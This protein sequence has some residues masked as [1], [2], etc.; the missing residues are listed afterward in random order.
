MDIKRRLSRQVAVGDIK[1]GGDAPISVQS[2]LNTKTTDVEGSIRQI[3][4]LKE[5]GCDLIRLAVPD[6]A[7]CEAF[8]KIARR[9]GLPL[10][11]D[12]H[13]SYKLAHLAL[14]NGAKKIR[15]NPGNMRD[16]AE[17]KP[18]AKHMIDMGVPVRVGV[19]GGSLDPK[20]KGM[21]EAKALS[22]S[23]LECAN[24]FESQG[25]RDIVVAIKASDT[26]IN[27]E[28]N[29]ILA[30]ACDYPLHIG[31]TE[32][33]TLRTGLIKSAIGIGTLLSE[34]IGDTIRV[35]LSADVTEEVL[36]GKKILQTLGVKKNAV[37]VVSCPTCARTEIDVEGL[38]NT[39]ER[40]TVGIS[41][42]LIISVL[43]CPL[44]GIGEGENSDLGIAGGKDKSVILL[45]GKI[46]KT[47]D[48]SS[49]LDEFKRLLDMKTK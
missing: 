4:A 29:R 11:A 40:M 22:E 25:M 39:V 14:D 47:V 15:I 38:A 49:L 31:V 5:V 33:G 36:A 9:T 43:G 45:D 18:L 48:N 21:D 24:V 26:N 1:I 7:S 27:I 12:V 30:K 19:N 37:E 17:I 3:N 32:A 44:N 42:P 41:K 6:E 2:M 35:S 46:Y 23:A 28:A 20:Y 10:I 8:G 13:Y 16:F 34:G